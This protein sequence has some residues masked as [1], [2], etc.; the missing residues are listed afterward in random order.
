MDAE[1]RVSAAISGI[2]TAMIDRYEARDVVALPDDA[3]STLSDMLRG[4]YAS[5]IR[6][7]GEIVVDGEKDCF[8]AFKQDAETFW[9]QFVED[10][11]RQ[12]GGLKI[13]Y[14]A[15]TT[16]L[17]IM[18]M[19]R[20]GQEQGLGI[21][22]IA[23]NMREKVPELS[24]LRSSVIARTETHS[25]AQ[26]GQMRTA[27]QSSRPLVKRW[28]SA[29]DYRT[30]D[31]GEGDGV[32]DSHNHRVMHGVTVPMDQPFLV[33]TKFGTSEP[34]MHPGDPAGTAGNV[35]NCRCAMTF[36]RADR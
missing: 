31:F 10:F 12:W 25:A 4:L 15:E 35:I 27:Q 34:L 29:E 13:Q 5:A 22:E 21:A 3:T 2:M 23:R 7:A 30:R 18:E 8:L 9:Q 16:R 36:R 20:E 14:I 24:A 17:Q 26:Y 19:I 32:V 1:A 28:S 33:P 6:D 11:F